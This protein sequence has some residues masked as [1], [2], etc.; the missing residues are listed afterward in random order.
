VLLLFGAMI[1]AIFGVYVIG[2]LRNLWIDQG[3]AFM[4]TAASLTLFMIL[5]GRIMTAA[6]T[7]RAAKSIAQ[8]TAPLMGQEDRLVFYDNYIEGLPF[9]LR[10]NKP[11][12]LVQSRQ[13]KELMGSIYVAE[14]RPT[15]A[16][17]YGQ[18]LF[19]FEE[20]TAEWKKNELPL[21]VFVKEKSLTRLTRELGEV[22]K[23]LMR[24]GD[25]VLV[26][27]R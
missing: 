24:F 19:T 13:K 1:V 10:L 2:D 25:V 6:S 9:Y 27:N 4:S 7:E 15:P 12:W 5:T 16:R 18:I 26:S 11:I 22:P 20:F 17:G 23:S 8:A 21:R 3:A 14:K